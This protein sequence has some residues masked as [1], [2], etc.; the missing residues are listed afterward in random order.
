MVIHE[1]HSLYI[2]SKFVT[3]ISSWR[4]YLVYVVCPSQVNTLKLSVQN[5]GESEMKNMLAVTAVKCT[6][7]TAVVAFQTIYRFLIGWIGKG[8][9]RALRTQSIFLDF[10]REFAKVLPIWVRSAY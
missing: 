1:V 7:V 3:F 10:Q 5:V 4:F 8:M 6:V 2:L 9:G